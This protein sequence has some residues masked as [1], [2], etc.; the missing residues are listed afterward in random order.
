MGRKSES[1][2]GKKEDPA[3]GLN[4]SNHFSESLKTVFRV[5]NT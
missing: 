1:G 2:M 4:N 5:K 3:S